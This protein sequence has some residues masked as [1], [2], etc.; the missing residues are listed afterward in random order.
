MILAPGAIL[1]RM[2]FRERLARL[3]PGRF[4]EVGAG[5]AHL[6]GVL[7]EYTISLMQAWRERHSP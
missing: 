2:Y 3:A 7:L 4:V 1:Q 5:Q 6:S